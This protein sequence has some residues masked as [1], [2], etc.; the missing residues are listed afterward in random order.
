MFPLYI[1]SKWS[2][3][4]FNWGEK[5]ICLQYRDLCLFNKCSSVSPALPRTELNTF[6]LLFALSRPLVF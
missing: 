2:G 5:M 3:K 1:F 6:F 4:A